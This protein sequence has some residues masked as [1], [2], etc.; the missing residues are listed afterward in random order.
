[1]PVGYV[2]D[3]GRIAKDPDAEVQNVVGML[4]DTF[5][6]TG[7]AHGVVRHFNSEGYRFPRKSGD[8]PL[9]SG[10]EWVELRLRHVL[11][12]LHNPCY[13]GVYSYGR[14]QTAWTPDGKKSKAAPRED[15]HAFIKDHH[16]AYISFEDFEENERRLCENNSQMKGGGKRTAAR[17]GP[18]LLQGLVWCGKCGCRMGVRYSCRGGQAIP[19][20]VCQRDSLEKGGRTCQYIDGQGVDGAI[21]GMLSSRLTPEAVAQSVAVQKELDKRQDESLNYYQMRVDRCKQEAALARRRFMAVDP[22]N[23]LVALELESD[24]NLKI[25]RLDDAMDEY[26]RQAEKAEKGRGARDYEAADRLAEN[27][28]EMFDSDAVS[29]KDKKRMARYLIEDV[30]LVKLDGAI[31]I[32]IRYKGYTTQ[33]VTIDAPKRSNEKYS[34][35]PDVIESVRMAA[36]TLIV[37]DIAALLNEKGLVSGKGKPFTPTIVKRIMHAYGIPNKKDRLLAR[38]YVVAAVK[39]ASL[40]ITADALYLQI[41]SGEYRGECVRVNSRNEYVFPPTAHGGITVHA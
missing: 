40:G 1:M 19:V 2:H 36:E 28:S 12:I 38:G 39:A 24:W 13:A 26:G 34:T 25:K 5:R 15:W 22:D 30:M 23:R 32:Q 21:A 18:S 6:R 7:S 8:G 29:L 37:E 31:K 3:G 4:F 33:S 14:T 10:A 27:F 9:G 35:P 17:E 11:G 16:D 20:Y 41:R